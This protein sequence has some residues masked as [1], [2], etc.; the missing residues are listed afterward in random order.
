[1]S[2]V[3]RVILT[4]GSIFKKFFEKGVW[5]EGAFFKKHP[6]PTQNTFL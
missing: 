6:L 3:E 4:G 5:G 1:M 2:R